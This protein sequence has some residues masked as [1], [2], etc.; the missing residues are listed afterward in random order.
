MDAKKNALPNYLGE[1]GIEHFVVHDLRRT[2][3]S[4]LAANGVPSHVAERCLNHKIRGA[5]GIYDRYDYMEE[6]KVALSILA[7][8]IAPLVNRPIVLG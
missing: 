3:R 7:E 1:A 2:C 6:R 8:Q 5:E 4:L